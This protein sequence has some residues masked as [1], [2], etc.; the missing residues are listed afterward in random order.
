[1]ALKQ[2]VRRGMGHSTVC[3]IASHP[4]KDRKDGPSMVGAWLRVGQHEVVIALA[5]C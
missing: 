5:A 4:C 3:S 2:K 1:M